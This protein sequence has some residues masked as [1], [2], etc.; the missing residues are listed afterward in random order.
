[1]KQKQFIYLGMIIG[2]LIVV[3]G[4]TFLSSEL[5]IIVGI[6]TASVGG[7]ILIFVGV[8]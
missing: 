8:M 6:T 5:N 4:I 3:L 7:V 1:V 2:C